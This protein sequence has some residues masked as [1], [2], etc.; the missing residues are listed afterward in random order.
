MVI[1]TKPWDVAEHL[2]SPEMIAAY[3]EVV[4]EEDDPKL[5]QAALGDIARA[6]GM[7]AIAQEAGVTRDALYKG[8]SETGDP[9]LSTLMGVVK[10]LG[11]HLSVRAS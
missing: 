2:N 11:L 6:R 9:R 5:L 3:L 10:A 7:T 4:L 8:L 1:E